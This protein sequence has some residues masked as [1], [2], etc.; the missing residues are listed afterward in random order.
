MAASLSRQNLPSKVTRCCVHSA[1]T[2]AANGRFGPP[3]PTPISSRPWL[4]W[5]RVAKLLARYTGLFSVETN[6]EQP[7]RSREV[8]AAA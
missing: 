7:I 8:H 3:V 5:S 2:N 4:S 6:T 1:C